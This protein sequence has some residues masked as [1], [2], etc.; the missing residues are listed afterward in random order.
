MPGAI[1]SGGVKIGKCFYMG[2]NSTII[3]NINIVDNSKIGAGACVV[4]NI[5]ISGTYTGVPAKLKK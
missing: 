5:D 2:T 3:E 1:V 4:K